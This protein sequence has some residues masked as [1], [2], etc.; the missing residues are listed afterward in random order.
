MET[1]NN[2]PAPEQPPAHQNYAEKVIQPLDP[3]L[4]ASQATPQSSPTPIVSPAS[5]AV[6]SSYDPTADTSYKVPTLDLRKSGIEEQSV[7]TVA[8]RHKSLMVL[9]I[10]GLLSTLFT[11]FSAI[12]FNHAIQ[13][14]QLT[15]AAGVG[16]AQVGL[17]IIYGGI[18][19]NILI[20]AYFLLAKDPHTVSTVLKVLLV[21]EFISVFGI[22]WGGSATKAVNLLIDGAF[23][24]YTFIVFNI[25]KTS[26]TI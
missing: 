10:M 5:T 22:F 13:K 3:N 7:K 1:E 18:V 15:N 4:T 23:L 21:L 9:A 11:I 25:V 24:L 6:A 14:A 20:Y 8:M 2:Q 12:Q 16:T 17:D 19:F 26:P